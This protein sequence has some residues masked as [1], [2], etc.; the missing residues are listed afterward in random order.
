MQGSFRRR[1]IF[2]SKSRIFK[3][4][5]A[6]CE[7]ISWFVRIVSGGVGM[8]Q[9]QQRR[10]NY[11]I[12]APG[13]VRNLALI[14]A[15][16]LMVGVAA[17]L[18]FAGRLQW[19]GIALGVV[20][21]VSFLVVEGE[22]LYMVWSSK[23]GKFRERER[24]LD[25][26]A[27]RGDEKVLDVGCGRG[28]VLHAAA[29]RLA[30]GGHAVGIDIWN[31]RDQS[32]NGPEATR[33]NA[34]MEGV[35]DRVEIVDGDA[36]SMPF[37]D[38]EFDV[39]VSSLALHNIPGAEERERAIREIMRVLKDGGRFAVLDFQHVREYADA[40]E[41][42][43]AVDVRIVGPHWLMFPPVRIAAGRKAAAT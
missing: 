39:V 35:A 23:V 2:A 13:V 21:A 17:F 7:S 33:R 26:V 25:L 6:N 15:G 43:G 14:G 24:L 12:D 3:E 1:R 4:R 34:D 41:R 19:L 32:G 22:A 28:L 37:A 42:L 10:G 20:C 36:R 40:F 16:F 38:G 30:A 18:A 31:K 27:L 5:K 9:L 8:G 29:R 11:G